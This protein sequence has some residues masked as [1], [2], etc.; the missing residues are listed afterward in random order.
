MLKFILYWATFHTLGRLPLAFLYTLMGATA[1]VAYRL[2]P[3]VR[4]NIDENLRHVAPEASEAKRRSW[5]KRILRNVALY[6]ADMARLP[7]MDLKEFFEKRL[8]FQRIDCALCF[9]S[10]SDG[11]NIISDG[12][13]QRS[14][15]AWAIA[16]W[17]SVPRARRIMMS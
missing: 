4:R 1:S 7:R 6:Y 2:A 3:S 14:S 17:R 13:H 15:A 16:R 11:P 12:H 5:A 9:D 10:A 8:I